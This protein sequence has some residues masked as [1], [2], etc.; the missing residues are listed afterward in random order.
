LFNGLTRPEEN[1]SDKQLANVIKSCFNATQLLFLGNLYY[2]TKLSLRHPFFQ[3]TAQLYCGCSSLLDNLAEKVVD[4]D[5][6]FWYDMVQV[7]A[8]LRTVDGGK[9]WQLV[10]E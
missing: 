3:H 9:N 2:T 7:E 5:I 1:A 4:S 6:D 10:S 8:I